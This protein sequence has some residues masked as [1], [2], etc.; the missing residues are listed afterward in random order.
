[1][2]TAMSL[3]EAGFCQC[4]NGLCASCGK[5]QGMTHSSSLFASATM[6]A[7]LA[8]ILSQTSPNLS[9]AGLAA[10]CLANRRLQLATEPHLYRSVVFDMGDAKRTSRTMSLLATLAGSA[11]H[12]GFVRKVYAAKFAASSEFVFTNIDLVLSAI[13]KMVR[14]EVLHCTDTWEFMLFVITSGVHFPGLHTCAIPYIGPSCG[15]F[16]ARHSNSLRNLRIHTSAAHLA[17][18]DTGQP[19]LQELSLPR[20]QTFVGPPILAELWLRQSHTQLCHVIL[21]CDRSIGPH[22]PT[23]PALR[24]LETARLESCSVFV[25]SLNTSFLPALAAHMP[26]VQF[27]TFLLDKTPI[28]EP[29]YDRFLSSVP[30]S[31]PALHRLT[32]LDICM[33]LTSYPTKDTPLASLKLR[34]LGELAVVRRWGQLCPLLDHVRLRSG[35]DWVRVLPD[36]GMWGLPSGLGYD[37]RCG[38]MNVA[39]VNDLLLVDKQQ[40]AAIS[41][42]RKR[43][44]GAF[45][46]A[47]AD[48]QRR[49]ANVER[50]RARLNALLKSSV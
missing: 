15:T 49:I 8:A 7:L 11:K 43:G 9:P 31:L 41:Q 16:V 10:V 18:R 12:A 29:D 35:W 33:F 27:V 46:A 19:I 14:L 37:H 3:V 38:G 48:M 39:E 25:S 30:D 1:M 6:D 4:L 40:A 45:E 50:M 20:L 22:V 13:E 28:A 5:S 32:S 2:A 34:I 23:K 36:R 17:L 26:K 21:S 47:L 24:L 44:P 42:L